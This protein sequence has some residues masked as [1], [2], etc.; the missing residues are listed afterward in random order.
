MPN[1]SDLYGKIHRLRGDRLRALWDAAVD[2]AKQ[3][4]DPALRQL[5]QYAKSLAESAHPEL[6][7]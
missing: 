3:S 7:A 6:S 4:P 5:A 2:V 1:T